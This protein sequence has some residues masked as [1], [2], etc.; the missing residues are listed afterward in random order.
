ML[1]QKSPPKKIKE[2]LQ[3]K[4][5]FLIFTLEILESNVHLSRKIPDGK[6][7]KGR[8]GNVLFCD[9]VSALQKEGFVRRHL[10]E[11]DLL[12]GRLAAPGNE[13]ND[14]LFMF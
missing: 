8:V 6:S 12:N 2:I 9:L 14:L 11:D 13:K 7:D 4:N 10:V 5:Q 3:K 1:D